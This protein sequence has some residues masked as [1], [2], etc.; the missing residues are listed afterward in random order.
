M[1]VR[2]P[3]VIGVDVFL[4]SFH[5]YKGIIE[6]FFA[7]PVKDDHGFRNCFDFPFKGRYGRNLRIFRLC[8]FPTDLYTA[9]LQ[10]HIQRVEIFPCVRWDVRLSTVMPSACVDQPGNIAVLILALPAEKLGL[11]DHTVRVSLIKIFY[12]VIRGFLRFLI[13]FYDQC[14]KVGFLPL[15]PGELHHVIM[16][17]FP[18]NVVVFV[19]YFLRQRLQGDFDLNTA[20]ANSFDMAEFIF[21]FLN[22]FFN[23][24]IC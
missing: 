1:V 10:S 4:A 2:K 15:F 3:D 12:V 5:T 22:R 19:L 18:L 11:C 21:I 8:V 24:T 17:M 7:F 13:V 16:S 23:S 20:P 9:F 6:R 14:L